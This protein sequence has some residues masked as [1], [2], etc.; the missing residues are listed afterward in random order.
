MFVEEMLGS[1]KNLLKK[2]K[3]VW[4]SFKNPISIN[5][6]SQPVQGLYNAFF[7]G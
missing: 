4:L 2:G 7:V 1:R 3:T 5:S 6:V